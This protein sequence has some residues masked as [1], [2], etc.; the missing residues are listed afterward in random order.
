ME[1]KKY[2]VDEKVYIQKPIV[3]AQYKQLTEILKNIVMPTSVTELNIALALGDS[4][5]RAFAIVLT[6]EGMKLQDKNLDVL[7]EEISFSFDP[8]TSL[9]VIRDFFVCNDISGLVTKI[10]E[11]VEFVMAKVEE[12][13]K[14]FTQKM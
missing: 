8:N 11:T 7:E 14:E 13:S 9:E 12:T 1:E 6:P 10:S 5:S 4:I 2:T 3:L